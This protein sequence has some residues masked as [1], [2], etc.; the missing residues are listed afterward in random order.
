MSCTIQCENELPDGGAIHTRRGTKTSSELLKMMDETKRS[1]L[2]ESFRTTA[3][4]SGAVGDVNHNV[5]ATIIDRS[6]KQRGTAS[7]RLVL[8][9]GEESHDS[10]S[11]DD[12]VA[13]MP[14]IESNEHKTLGHSPDKL[15]KCS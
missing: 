10:F 1:G 2:A 14:C 4:L 12:V 13:R 6:S 5:L 11:A 3:W 7:S 9:L 8:L 15:G